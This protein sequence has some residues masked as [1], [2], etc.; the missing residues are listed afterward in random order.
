ML[1]KI[2]QITKITRNINKLKLIIYKNTNIKLF[3]YHRKTTVPVDIFGNKTLRFRKKTNLNIFW[4]LKKTSSLYIT[5][6][7]ITKI[8][9]SFKLYKFISIITNA[10]GMV[11]SQLTVEHHKLFSYFLFLNNPK[12]LRPLYDNK[13][14]FLPYNSFLLYTPRRAFI[15]NVE[16]SINKGFQYALSIGSKARLLEIF[17]WK[18]LCAVQLPSKEVKI[19]SAFGTCINSLLLLNTLKYLHF[20]NKRYKRLSGFG[21]NVRGVAMNAVDHPH[22][23]KTKSVKFPKTPWGLPTKL[24]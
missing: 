11:Y 15:S 18:R 9:F 22:G 3:S 6:N 13:I 23:G 10:N 8:C 5:P 17:K 19:F 24:K 2:K 4:N 7:L 21:P 20:D 16:L 14:D 1:I 12:Y